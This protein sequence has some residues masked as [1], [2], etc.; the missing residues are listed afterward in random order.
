MKFKTLY[1]ELKNSTEMIRALLAGISQEEARV[2]PTPETWSILEVTCHLHDEEREDFR[3]RLQNI[4]R[5]QNEEFQVI[6][7]QDWVTERKYNEQNFEEMQ[8]K[9]FAERAKSLEWLQGLTD[10]DWNITHTDQYGSVT[11]GEMLSA[12]IAHDNLHIRQLVEL[13]RA[14]IEKITQPYII[15]YAGEW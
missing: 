9:F 6:N 10:A 14:R 12:W 7:P 8:R 5:G 13:R 2:K 4:L 11:A 15:E 3:A 1:Q